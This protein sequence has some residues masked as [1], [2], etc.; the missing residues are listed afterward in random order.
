MMAPITAPMM[1]PVQS[2]TAECKAV[3]S[4]FTLVN[5]DLK[6]DIMPLDD[7]AMT[8]T[9]LNIRADVSVC[10]PKVVDS[11]LLVLDGK[12]RCEQFEPYAIF[13]D[14]SK[15]DV[16]SDAARYFG[17]KIGRGNH[18]ITATP[19]SG[20]KCDGDAGETFTQAF[21]VR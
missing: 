5:A 9:K 11:V 1:A 12:S 14:D 3:I 7:F 8:R 13:G 18:I 21:I 16:A 10:V 2:P 15:T 20:G 17:V 4:G 19:Y 6:K